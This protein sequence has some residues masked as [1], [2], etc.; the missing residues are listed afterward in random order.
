MTC[1]WGDGIVAVEVE[2]QVERD[3]GANVGIE[4]SKRGTR[5]QLVG[6][7]VEGQVDQI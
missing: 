7:T 5:G 3:I 4:C 1:W 6:G 2:S